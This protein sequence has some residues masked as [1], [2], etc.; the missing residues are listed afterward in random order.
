MARVR[1]S[2]RSRVIALPG[3]NDRDQVTVVRVYVDYNLY[4]VE[5]IMYRV[6]AKLM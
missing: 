4:S 2:D 6:R 1:K 5:Y 3:C